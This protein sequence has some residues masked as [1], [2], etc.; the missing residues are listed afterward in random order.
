[1]SLAVTTETPAYHLSK[2]ESFSLLNPGINWTGTHR[3]DSDVQWPYGFFYEIPEREKMTLDQVKDMNKA[4]L[5]YLKSNMNLLCYLERALRFLKFKKRP[6]FF[7][8]ILS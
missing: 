5:R 2:F 7:Y 8:K 3:S 4:N 1:M 6:S